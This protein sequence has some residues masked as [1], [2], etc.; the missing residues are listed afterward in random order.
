[1]LNVKDDILR[2]IPGGSLKGATEFLEKLHWFLYIMQSDGRV[3]LFRGDRPMFDADSMDAVEA[4]V[5][6]ALMAYLSLPE[7]VFKEFQEH[8]GPLERPSLPGLTPL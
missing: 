3:Y 7:P 2:R 8:W 5:Y 1:L 4:F 6:G